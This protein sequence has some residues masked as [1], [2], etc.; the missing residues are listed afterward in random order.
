MI[1]VSTKFEQTVLGKRK[2]KQ[3]MLSDDLAYNMQLYYDGY[4]PRYILNEAQNKLN[5]ERERLNAQNFDVHT[6]CHYL[7]PSSEEVI[8]NT[9]ECT[10][11]KCPVS[12]T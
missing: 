4:D 6:F 2:F 10:Y 12:D 11:C 3:T 8:T 7:E 5:F 1:K 9:R